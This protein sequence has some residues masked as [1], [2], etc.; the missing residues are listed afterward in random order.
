MKASY[1]VIAA[2]IIFNVGISKRYNAYGTYEQTKAIAEL[3]ADIIG[4]IQ[5]NLGISD[6]NKLT[7]WAKKLIIAF[8]II[9]ITSKQKKGDKSPFY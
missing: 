8:V 7:H 5:W 1:R 4:S 9:K 2:N 3:K 6:K